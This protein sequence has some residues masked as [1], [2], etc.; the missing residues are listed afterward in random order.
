MLLFV[1]EQNPAL[2]DGV[3]SRSLD[4]KSSEPGSLVIEG[5]YESARPWAAGHLELAEE[6]WCQALG[7]GN[8]TRTTF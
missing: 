8:D 2:N 4:A 5:F 6:E 7:Q 1:V 3:N